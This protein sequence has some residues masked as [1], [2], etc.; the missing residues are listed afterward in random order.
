MADDQFI[1]EIR[2]FAFGHRPGG[3]VSCDGQM[4]ST[5]EQAKL[6]KVIG[7]TYGGQGDQFA[8]P[9]L[10]GRVAV[11]AGALSPG[12]VAGQEHVTLTQAMMPPHDHVV[13]RRGVSSNANKHNVPAAG[14]YVG[15]LGVMNASGTVVS[16]DVFATAGAG[17]TL[18]PSTVGWVDGLGNPL[19]PDHLAVPPLPHENR[20][21]F[22]VMHFC[23][24]LEGA[25]P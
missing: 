13:Q 25:K 18:S 22:L 24:A 14:A 10:R 16:D 1:G 15:A 11:G 21:P 6:F 7:H 17:T 8:V 19:P 20:Q 3:W 2:A 23:I 4:Y 5:T 9:D 12:M